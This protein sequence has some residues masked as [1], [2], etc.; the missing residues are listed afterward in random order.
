[1]GEQSIRTVGF[2]LLSF[3]QVQTTKLCSDINPD[4]FSI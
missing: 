4:H 2:F 1:M 3:I